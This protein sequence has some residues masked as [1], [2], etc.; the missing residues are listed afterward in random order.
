MFPKT[1]SL[2]NRRKKKRRMLS[3]TIRQLLRDGETMLSQSNIEDARFDAFCLMQHATGTDATHLR[4]R[5]AD[6][7]DG[8]AVTFDSGR[9]YQLIAAHY[10]PDEAHLLPQGWPEGYYQF[11]PA[12]L[13]K[14]E[15]ELLPMM[16]KY[17]AVMRRKLAAAEK[18]GH[19]PAALIRE[20]KCTA[21]LIEMYLEC[22]GTAAED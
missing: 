20:E 13:E 6:A 3:K 17:L 8:E 9:Y 5:Y 10:S 14:R 22:G 15:A 16:R 19:V 12:A 4:T 18:K 21:K 1:S 2:S 11:G 7:I